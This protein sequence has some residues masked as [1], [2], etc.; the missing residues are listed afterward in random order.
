VDAVAL[1]LLWLAVVLPVGISAARRR[2][3]S[4]ADFS[5][6]LD[7]LRPDGTPVVAVHPIPVAQLGRDGATRRA[8]RR[9]KVVGLLCVL[10]AVA[11]VVAVVSRTR[12]AVGAGV[13]LVDVGLAYA[14]AIVA[15]D[16][17]QPA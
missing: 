1:V 4:I 17:R 3:D 10:V 5:R 2:R 6:A 14:A 15:A 8:A 11:M 12:V 7:S 16:Q 13:L 9:R